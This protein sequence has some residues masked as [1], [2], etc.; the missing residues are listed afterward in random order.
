MVVPGLVE[1]GIGADFGQT[2]QFK[3]FKGSV[4]W[5]WTEH[6]EKDN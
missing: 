2:S 3:L 6:H 4:F 5:G 1:L